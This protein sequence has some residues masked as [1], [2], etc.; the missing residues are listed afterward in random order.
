MPFLP[1][2]AR[3]VREASRQPRTYRWRW[4]TAA[5]TLGLLFFVYR[6]TRHSPSQGRD[7]FIAVSTAAYIYC[8][9]AG[10]VRDFLRSLKR[11]HW[12]VM[13]HSL[14]VIARYGRLSPRLYTRYLLE[15]A[16]GRN[17]DAM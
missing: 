8:L 3:E 11:R 2:A 5:A 13:K 10:A 9:L 7:L 1:V 12:P 6:V 17:R 4:V 15:L 14:A 16:S